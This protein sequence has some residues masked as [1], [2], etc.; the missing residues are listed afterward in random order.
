MDL[1]S[2]LV[3]AVQNDLTVG[4]E[5]TLFDPA[6][7]KLAV[8]RAYRKIAASHKWPQRK[9]AKK[10]ST[11]AGQ[12]YYDYPSNW[13][14]DSVW[15]VV[16]DGIDYGDPLQFKDYL[17]E[18]E[19]NYP[20]GLTN[21]WANQQNRF[22]ITTNR[23]APSANG[24]NNIFVWGYK[25][26]D[27]VVN[28]GDTTIFSYNMQEVNEAIVL[29]ATAILKQ[30]G[31][32]LQVMRRLYMTGSEL[33]SFQATAIVERAWQTILQEQSKNEKTI[34]MMEVP[35]FFPQGRNRNQLKWNIG[36]FNNNN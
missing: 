29:E 9:D 32:I 15:K 24:D 31:E 11:I 25:I 27:A 30:K 19:N 22:F 7:A 6:T 33:L 18:Q 5:S 3:A 8:Q 21:L 20:S 16:V 28:D 2:D 35:D 17:S 36:N 10:T 4:G 34:P 23:A 26:A 1:L 12:E 14:P 13:T